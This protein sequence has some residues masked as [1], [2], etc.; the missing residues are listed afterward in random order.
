MRVAIVGG[1]AAGLSTALHLA[2]LVSQGYI[3][4]PIDIFEADSRGGRDIG[5]GIW[6]T[7]LDPFQNSDRDSHQLVYNDMVRHGTCIRDVGYRT[8]QGHWLATSTLNDSLPGLLFLREVD[9]ISSLQ[10]AV[11]LE[12]LRGTVNLHSGKGFQ[13]SSICEQSTDPWA[14]S[15]VLKENEQ[16]TPRDY[17]LIVAADGM[18]SVLRKMYGGHI[19]KRHNLTGTSALP[20][21]L[22]LPINNTPTPDWDAM[23]Q[24]EATGTQDRHYT[25]FRGNANISTKE[26]GQDVSFQTWGERRSMR[27]A[28]VPMYYPDP[29]AP[30][31]RCERQ[32]WFATTNDEAIAA[33]KDPAVRRD[34]LLENFKDWHDPVCRLMEATGPDDILMERAM[35]HK[36]SMGP[37]VNFN[38]IITKLRNVQP[39]S[40]GNGPAI[41][42]MGDAFMCVDPILAQGFTF[43]ME[44]AAAL[45]RSV[46][47]ST[48]APK[49]P[50][51]PK[52]AFD[53]EAL[54]DELKL[55]HELRLGRLINLLRATELVQ[56]LGQPT[57]GTLSGLITRAI[58]RPLMRITPGFIKTPIFN[59]M[60]K[61][62]LGVSQG[63]TKHQEHETK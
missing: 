18:N 47:Q 15:L 22:D 29:E 60:L 13:I 4:G 52:L 46:D 55:R 40:S 50:E 14:A 5:V 9:M 33:E 63:K 39:Q 54:R 23:G 49:R 57:S 11:H 20:S 37:V 31:K 51:F 16:R 38:D 17:H 3:D 48:K 59:G 25:V 58:L 12:E 2:P 28:T 62:S 30:G 44:G 7:A 24:A 56:A 53:P 61:Y 27:F 42:F 21:P 32:V 8:P 35:A 36:H 10:K 6:S 1:G 43:G 34:M 41:A 26:T 19:H 45:A